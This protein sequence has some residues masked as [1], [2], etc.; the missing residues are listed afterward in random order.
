LHNIIFKDGLKFPADEPKQVKIR[1]D[2]QN[3]ELRLVAPFYNSK[4]ICVIPEKTYTQCT[5]ELTDKVCAVERCVTSCQQPQWNKLQ[6]VSEDTM[7]YH[8]PEFQQLQEFTITET[9]EG[10]GKAVVKPLSEFASQRSIDHWLTH[11]GT[12]DAGLYLAGVYVWFIKN[13]GIALPQSIGTFRFGRLPKDNEKCSL[14]VVHTR[15]EKHI[16]FFDVVCSGEDGETIYS[17]KD[18]GAAVIPASVKQ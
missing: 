16:I 15:E 5:A 7:M 3:G 6:Y 1:F 4:G 18:Y 11:P 14:R 12:V 8:G 9:N 17:M 2:S 10:F 13:H